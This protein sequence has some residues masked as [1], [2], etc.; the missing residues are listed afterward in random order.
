M[1]KLFMFLGVICVVTL[2]NAQDVQPVVA[3]GNNIINLGIGLGSTLYTGSG[4]SGMIPP[5]SGSFEHIVK[6]GVLEGKAA[7]GIGGYIGYSAAKW[8]TTWTDY[9]W[10]ST[11]SNYDLINYKYGWNYSNIIVGPRGTFHYQ[12][13]NKFDT[14]TGLL[15]GYDIVSVKETG[16]F[17]GSLTT[18]SQSS[19]FI[20][21]WYVGGRYFFTDKFAGMAELGYGIAYLNLGVAFK[22]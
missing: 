15:L 5:V 18:N 19:A 17:P 1:K 22:L 16:T 21:S 20:W 2:A 8:E 10:N 13:A 11:T 12:F 14:Y 4:Y 7:W 6:D 3:K 9:V